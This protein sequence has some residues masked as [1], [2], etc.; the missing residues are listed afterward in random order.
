ME[1]EGRVLRALEFPAGTDAAA[2]A[3][4]TTLKRR[5]A[6][7]RRHHVI[8]PRTGYPVTGLKSVTIICPDAE[9][10]DALATAVFVL[11]REEGLYL[12]NQLKGVECLMI[13]DEDEMV[14]SNNLH[15]H[16]YKNK[17][18]PEKAAIPAKTSK[19]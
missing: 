17:P 4:S 19:I 5:W 11:G 15:L 2:V 8:D 14:T 13:T 7:G 3:T 16:F 1:P 18:Q 6:Q 9:L 12:I 10:A